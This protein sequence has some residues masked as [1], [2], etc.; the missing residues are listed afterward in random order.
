MKQFDNIVYVTEDLVAD[1]SAAVARAISLAKNNQA[2]LTMLYV[3]EKPFLGPF[4]GHLAIEDFKLQLRQQAISRMESWLAPVRGDMEI[5]LV[6]KFGTPFI[7]VIRDALRND[8]DLV[9]KPAGYGGAH[10]FLFGGL[11]RHLLRSCPCPVWILYGDVRSN[12]DRIV[13]TV[14][15]NPFDEDG[16]QEEFNR[17]ILMLAA[18]LAV[19]DF[20]ELHVAHAWQPVTD[21]IVRVFSSE[22]SE[23]QVAANIESERLGHEQRLNALGAGLRARLGAEAYAYLA[24]QFHLRKGDPRTVIPE[25][26]AQ[27]RADLVVMGTVGRSGIPG[28]IIGNTAEVILNNTEC[29]VLAIKPDG[30]VSPI[31]P[32]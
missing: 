3:A 18:G 15:F 10:A 23:S 8:R 29:S 28:L 4:S 32:A 7:E 14:D 17:R 22:L 25:I 2:S 24:P 12:Y 19:S 11:D 5:P 20:A 9:I 16:R 21:N 27:L 13:A 30:F 6:V 31:G 26:V 1:Q